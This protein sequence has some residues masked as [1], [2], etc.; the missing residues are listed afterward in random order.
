V[1]IHPQHPQIAVDRVCPPS[2]VRN[3]AIV[4]A[5]TI[6]LISAA[7]GASS[8]WFLCLSSTDCIASR[9]ASVLRT[10]SAPEKYTGTHGREKWSVHPAFAQPCNADLTQIPPFAEVLSHHQHALNSID[11]AVDPDHLCGQLP[12]WRRDLFCL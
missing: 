2:T 10:A 9:R 3:T 11:V 1:V 4:C 5:F 8:I 7:G 6:R 12:R